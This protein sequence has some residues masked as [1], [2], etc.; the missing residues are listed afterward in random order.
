MIS[1]GSLSLL[2]SVGLRAELARSN[3]L[4][5][6]VKR[7]DDMGWQHWTDFEL[8]H[9]LTRADLGRIYQDYTSDAEQRDVVLE[10]IRFPTAEFTL[11]SS[12]LR[13]LEFRN[14]VVARSVMHQDAL[15][16]AMISMGSFESLLEIIDEELRRVT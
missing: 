14:I 2:E 1:S 16:N 12:A 15:A 10:P 9:L 7:F 5:D 6:N 3:E 4:H 11:P 13:S 8:P